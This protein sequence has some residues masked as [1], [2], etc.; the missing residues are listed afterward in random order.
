MGKPRR[1]KPKPSRVRI[2]VAAPRDGSELCLS[3]GM[4]C[5][6]SLFGN[7]ALLEDEVDLARALGMEPFQS[8]PSDLTFKFR[9]PCRV[10]RRWLF[11]VY[12][13]EKPSVCTSYRC[14][15][16]NRYAAGTM[17]L[18]SCLDVVG[19]MKGLVRE[20]EEEMG[21]AF[22]EF[23]F[24]HLVAYAVTVRPHEDPQRFERFLLS[25]RRYLG[26]GK[27]LFTFPTA[28]IEAIVA[29]AERAS[30]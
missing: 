4:C 6:G 9:Q 12:D 13:Q 28:E 27:S 29:D 23:T 22:G 17:D 25:C 8:S 16:L 14:E 19:W 3:C 20:L 26:L 5:D 7:G 21:V 18:G 10:L 30:A 24:G 1:R 15:L 2:A 11:A